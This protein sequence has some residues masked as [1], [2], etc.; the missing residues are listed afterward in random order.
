[1]LFGMKKNLFLVLLL[2][3]GT[4]LTL[5]SDN[6]LNGGKGL[7]M[8][9]SARFENE[10]AV[11]FII[12]NYDPI[13][14]INL[15]A[16][17]FSW[18]EAQVYYNDINVRRY[19]P[20]SKQSYKDKGFSFKL[21]LK[22]EG[23]LPAIAIGFEDIAGTSIFKSEYIVFSK[24]FNN[25]DTS[26]GMGFGALASRSNVANFLR[27]G[28]RSEW[29]FS[30]GGEIV[31][32]FFKGDAAIFGGI[33]YSPNFL[34]NASFMVEYD[35][36]DYSTYL[37]L[38][39]GYSRYEP[40]SRFNYGA[41]YRI[42]E[43]FS[44]SLGF[45]K[46]DELSASFNSKILINQRANKI[47][48]ITN[49]SKSNNKYVSVLEDLRDH[50][51]YVQNATFDED[52]KQLYVNYSQSTYS[53][54]IE[55]ADRIKDYLRENYSRDY[56]VIL[57]SN[58][59]AFQLS[60][61]SYDGFSELPDPESPKI[62]EYEFNP[63]VIYPIY[64]WNLQPHLI[65]HIGSPAGFFFGGIQG[66]FSSEVAINKNF[67][68]NS[69]FTFPIYDNFD[70]LSYYSNPTN[71]YPVRT[72][73]QE[74]LKQGKTG[75]DELTLN[76]YKDLPQNNF[77]QISVGHFEQM[78]SGIF[79]EY[80]YRPFNNFFSIGA[81]FSRVYQ[82]AYN[83]GL[84]SF[85]DYSVN[86][87]HVNLFAYEQKNR[88]LLKLSYGQYLAKDKGFTLEFSRYFKNGA[89]IGAF[90]SLT[91]IRKEEFGEGSFDKGIF[92]RY[93]INI[94]N[95]SRPSRT[96]SQFLYRPI[97]RDGAAK[98]HFPRSLFDLTKDSQMIELN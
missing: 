8:T 62:K 58:N 40:K 59:G 43:N 91:D 84:S 23:Y 55:L 18:L 24:K 66:L 27:G 86:T 49:R 6:S 15:I 50:S 97:T 19:Y 78:Y 69:S 32:D 2:S 29:D 44:F 37:D 7:I 88:I 89:R 14:K 46:G 10:G 73:I 65:S 48:S 82:R 96:T 81:E 9:P 38:V 33:S 41:N 39:P 22:N 75:F 25:F 4:N 16:Y 35:T 45:I 72:D 36:D 92:I 98:L 30:T 42:N 93:P 26:I 67:Q 74:Y 51:I 71:L 76:F 5:F 79:G 85:K 12:S 13:N 31:D 47:S 61:I 54:Q 34:K 57:I 80:L 21:K 63:R 53:D 70:D 1:M 56:E 60:Q 17:P 52:R 28:S 77:L 68:V 83:K 11:K 95:K 64:V 94:F 3:L 90:F 20:G 87:A